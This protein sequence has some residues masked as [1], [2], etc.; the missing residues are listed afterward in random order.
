MF[1]LKDEK[2]Y[3]D[4]FFQINVCEVM[5]HSAPRWCVSPYWGWD[6]IADILQITFAKTFSWM[7]II[8]F[9]FK[10][11]WNL[12]LQ[13]Q[14]T[15]SQ[16]LFRQAITWTNDDIINSSAPSAAYISHCIRSALVV[17][18]LSPGQR[19]AII[20]ASAEIL[21]IGPSGIN[22]S[23]ILIKISKFSFKKMHWKFRLRNGGHFVQGEM[24]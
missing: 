9:W 7:K 18:G 16:Y 13:V 10:I 3:L 21:F 20:W 2:N 22:F 1:S 6:K 17:N 8:V 12:F 11:H 23:E 24:S 15:M 5:M 14:L 19:Q 4:V